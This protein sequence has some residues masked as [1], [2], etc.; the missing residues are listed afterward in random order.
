MV[1]IAGISEDQYYTTTARK[2]QQDF[3]IFWTIDEKTITI[4]Q[5]FTVIGIIIAHGGLF[6][7]NFLNYF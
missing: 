7:F 1:P 6:S 3:G 2:N 5:N 4:K